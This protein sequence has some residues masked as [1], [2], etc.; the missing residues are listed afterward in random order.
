[1]NVINKEGVEGSHVPA[2]VLFIFQ[3]RSERIGKEE[4]GEEELCET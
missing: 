1:M 4:G 2:C 3:P